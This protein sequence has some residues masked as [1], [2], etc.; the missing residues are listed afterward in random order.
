VNSLRLKPRALAGGTIIFLLGLS[1]GAIRG[2][3]IG[4]EVLMGAGMVLLVLGLFL[5]DK[6]SGK[7]AGQTGG[8]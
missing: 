6:P 1:L 8:A 2:Y 4:Y 5:K 3:G 7:T